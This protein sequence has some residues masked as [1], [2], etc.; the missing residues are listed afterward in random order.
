MTEVE[1]QFV[2]MSLLSREERVLW[3]RFV[4]THAA[5]V[6]RLEEGAWL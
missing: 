4:E 2:H 1:S 6:R 5:I 3:R